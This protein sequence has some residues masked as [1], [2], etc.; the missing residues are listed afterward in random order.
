M[1]CTYCTVLIVLY[2]LYCTYCTVLI[3]LY[4]LFCTYCTYCIILYLLYLFAFSTWDYSKCCTIQYFCISQGKTRYQICIFSAKLW[5]VITRKPFVR[6]SWNFCI[7]IFLL[8]LSGIDQRRLGDRPVDHDGRVAHTRLRACGKGLTE[9]LS[10]TL[11]LA[12]RRW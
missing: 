3:P 1:C 12:H 11:W 10:I 7:K 8:A 2:L 5:K 4:L 9:A 6:L